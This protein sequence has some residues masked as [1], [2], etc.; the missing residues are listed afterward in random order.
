[1]KPFCLPLVETFQKNFRCFWVKGPIHSSRISSLNSKLKKFVQKIKYEGVIAFEIFETKKEFLI[2]EI[3]P[4]VHNSGHYSLDALTQ[5][6]FELHL[7]ACLRN[8][9]TAPQLLGKGFAMLNLLGK[10]ESNSEWKKQKNIFL[11]MYGK[12]EKTKMRKM[13]H[14]NALD[15]TPQKALKKLFKAESSFK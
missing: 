6:Q 5:D 3:A 15:Q 8:P 1:M 7:E 9:L 4:R 12:K 11:H 14:L 2:N 10:Q 13:G